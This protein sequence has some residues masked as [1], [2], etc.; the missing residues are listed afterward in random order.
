MAFKELRRGVYRLKR[1]I[2]C[3]IS[4]SITVGLTSCSQVTK[5]ENPQ[6]TTEP[7]TEGDS[8]QSKNEEVQKKRYNI[9]E[10]F[11]WEDF[12][13]FADTEKMAKTYSN[14][15]EEYFYGDAFTEFKKSSGQTDDFKYSLYE[16]N[17]VLINEYIGGQ[18]NVKIPNE[19]DGHKVIGIGRRCS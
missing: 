16:N 3:L 8:Q 6:A 19:I 9:S 4:L 15:F 14:Y 1:I 13:E 5:T 11:T 10:N 12:C 18:S 7:T 17:T 2:A